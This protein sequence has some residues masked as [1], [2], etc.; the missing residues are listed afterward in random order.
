MAVTEYVTVGHALPVYVIVLLSID[1][2]FVGADGLGALYLHA[3]LAV[4]RAAELYSPPVGFAP[5]DNELQLYFSPETQYVPL[6]HSACPVR[7]VSVP[8]VE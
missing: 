6:V 2:Q 4:D 5:P 3:V 8:P 1:E 7:V